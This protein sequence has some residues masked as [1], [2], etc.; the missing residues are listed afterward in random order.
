MVPL[1]FSLF[2]SPI[3]LRG[4]GGERNVSEAVRFLTLAADKG[5][6]HAQFNLA[7]LYRSGAGAKRDLRKAYA[8][9]NLAGETL[10]VS[11]QLNEI[12]SELGREDSAA[13]ANHAP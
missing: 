11:N 4:Q 2:G 6:A 3:F 13:N 10:D 7:V 9:F 5:N 12:S 8:L 1:L